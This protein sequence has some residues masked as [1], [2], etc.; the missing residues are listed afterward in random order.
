MQSMTHYSIANIPSE[1]RP[2]E[3]LLRHGADV[4]SVVELI[5][6][7][8]GSGTKTAPVL[9]L[10]QMIVGH[11]TDLNQLADATIEELCQIKGIGPAKAIQLK[12]CFTLGQRLSRQSQDSKVRID[13]PAQAY[14]LLKSELEK[15]KQEVFVV[16]LQDVKNYLICHQVVSMGTLSRALIHPR[17]VFYPAIRHKAAS[18]IL[19]HNHPSGDPTPSAEDFEI[20]ET[21]CEAGKMIGISV[22]DHLI[23]GNQKFTSLRQMGFNFSRN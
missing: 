11:F 19:A 3:R 10:A 4:L 12:A 16:I 18:L 21:I 23:I 5:A 1:E 20:T 22:N 14:Q 17:E 13:Q 15:E 9:Q 2:R 7:L 8:L 6:I